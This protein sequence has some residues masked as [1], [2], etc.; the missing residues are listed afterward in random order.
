MSQE[1]MKSHEDPSVLIKIFEGEDQ[2]LDFFKDSF[3]YQVCT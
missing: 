2:S 1:A 3:S